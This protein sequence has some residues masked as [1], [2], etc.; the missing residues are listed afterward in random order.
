MTGPS[1]LSTRVYRAGAG[2]PDEPAGVWVW[3]DDPS[4]RAGDTRTWF[5]M[6]V[7]AT[8]LHVGRSGVTVYWTLTATGGNANLAAASSVTGADGVATVSCTYTSAGGVDDI[9]VVAGSL[10]AP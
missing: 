9:V 7:D 1:T 6:L 2:V 3:T 4:P 10:T 5:G 8:G